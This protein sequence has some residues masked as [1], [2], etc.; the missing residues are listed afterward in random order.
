MR[1]SAW[2]HLVV[3]D[4]RSNA[5]CHSADNPGAETCAFYCTFSAPDTIV[6]DDQAGTSVLGFCQRDPD[7]ARAFRERIFE[8]VRD[9]FG[10][11]DAEIYGRVSTQLQRCNIESQRG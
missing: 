10:D 11:D 7:L 4:F 2:R 1:D 5:G 8:S 6:A 9:E 3:G